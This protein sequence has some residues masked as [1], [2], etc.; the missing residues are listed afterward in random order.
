ME[1]LNLAPALTDAM[2]DRLE[3]EKKNDFKIGKRKEGGLP[4]SLSRCAG[5]FGKKK[6]KEK[7]I[8]ESRAFFSLCTTPT[9]S[10]PSREEIFPQMFG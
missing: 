7:K 1:K 2:L 5:K 3:Q 10:I 8:Y 4:P 6:K 9:L